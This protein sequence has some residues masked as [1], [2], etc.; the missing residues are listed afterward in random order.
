[1]LATSFVK[2]R[3]PDFRQI[4]RTSNMQRPN[5]YRQVQL[6]ND[7]PDV[8]SKQDIMDVLAAADTSHEMPVEWILDRYNA[9]DGEMS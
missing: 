1:M 7:T 9:R 3:K 4:E 6:G 2:P 5:E 8:P